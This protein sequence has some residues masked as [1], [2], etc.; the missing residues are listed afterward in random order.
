MNAVERYNLL[1]IVT[2]QIAFLVEY[3][4]QLSEHKSEHLAEAHY[5]A[6]GDYYVA[7]FLAE[8]AERVQAAEATIKLAW[9]LQFFLLFG[10]EGSC[11]AARRYRANLIRAEKDKVL[12]AKR[13]KVALAEIP[14]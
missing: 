7:D 1:G 6:C 2:R 11:E 8:H 12:A 5:P 4:W 14:F 9:E 13:W 10:A 3:L